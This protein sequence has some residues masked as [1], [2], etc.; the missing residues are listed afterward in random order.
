[1]ALIKRRQ[2]ETAVGGGNAVLNCLK[3]STL[4][5]ENQKYFMAE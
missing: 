3:M 1:M 5:N 2:K 4:Q